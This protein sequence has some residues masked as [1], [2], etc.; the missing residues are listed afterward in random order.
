MI[1]GTSSIPSCSS[2]HPSLQSI[3]R[4]WIVSP[5]I[6]MTVMLVNQE[7]DPTSG[8]HALVPGNPL[9]GLTV[10]SLNRLKDAHNA[11]ESQP[12]SAVLAYR[13]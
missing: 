11:G 1:N 6:F 9:L 4:N 7:I 12:N 13:G 3:R 10:S 5:F 2:L 8:E